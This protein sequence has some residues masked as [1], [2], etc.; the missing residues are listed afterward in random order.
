MGK[1]FKTLCLLPLKIRFEL[2]KGIFMCK[3]VFESVLPYLKQLFQVSWPPGMNKITVKIPRT[4]LFKSSLT[5]TRAILWNSLPE[6]LKNTISTS[7]FRN[8]FVNHL[9]AKVC[10][11]QNTLS[12]GSGHWHFDCTTDSSTSVTAW[13]SCLTHSVIQLFCYSSTV[14]LPIHSVIW[15]LH[16]STTV[17]F[18]ICFT[19]WLVLLYFTLITLLFQSFYFIIHLCTSTFWQG[20]IIQLLSIFRFLSFMYKF[21]LP[22]TC[23]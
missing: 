1:D 17:H 2:N 5:Y 9:N 4:D 7:S 15:L 12:V 22:L 23:L 19:V 3:I 11:N 8:R 20:Y 13:I 18:Q 14:Y 16:Y 6:S 10:S 21:I